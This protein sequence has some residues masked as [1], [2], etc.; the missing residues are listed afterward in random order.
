MAAGDLWSGEARNYRA[1]MR[2]RRFWPLPLLGL[3]LLLPAV[4]FLTPRWIEGAPGACAAVERRAVEV[5]LSETA[6]PALRAAARGL[7][8]QTLDGRLVAPMVAERYQWL[9]VPMGCA[10]AYWRLRWEG[11]E[12]LTWVAGLPR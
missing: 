11:A 5:A 7:S 4:V 8:R 9:P 2:R 3:V 10:L 1:S 12:A 6:P